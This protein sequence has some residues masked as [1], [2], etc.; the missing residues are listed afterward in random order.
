MDRQ[1]STGKRVFG[2]DLDYQPRVVAA[3]AHPG[4]R[5]KEDGLI[6]KDLSV[7]LFALPFLRL[8]E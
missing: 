6:G 8:L 1:P 3:R 4:E 2:S 5:E 7:L